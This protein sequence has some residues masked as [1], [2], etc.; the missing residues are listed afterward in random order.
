MPAWVTALSRIIN[1]VANAINKYKASKAVANPADTIA[2]NGRVLKSDQSFED[3]VSNKP[4]GGD[5]T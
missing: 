2:G 4:D 5:A 3:I 1:G